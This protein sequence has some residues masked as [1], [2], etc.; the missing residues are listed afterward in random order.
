MNGRTI[1]LIIA[2]IV[3]IALIIGGIVFVSNQNSN[4]VSGNQTALNT[5]NSNGNNDEVET[6]TNNSVEQTPNNENSNNKILVAYF[7]RS[8]N[9]E[10]IANEIH[11][12]VGGDIIKIETVKQYPSDYNATTAEARTEQ[13]ENARPELKTKIDNIE[14]YDTIFVGYPNWWGTMP[15][16]LFTFFE[17]YDFNE[18]TVIPFCTHE[19]S[20]LGRSEDDIK[21]IIG[22]DIVKKR[23]SNKRI[24]SRQCRKYIKTMANRKWFLENGKSN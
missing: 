10:K 6:N 23:I 2:V 22:T 21:G 1:G 18:K 11:N 19:G 13:D 14:Q 24:V 20:G 8:G 9:T 16:A 4:D 5:N 15:M 12:I 3:I 17:E 7:S